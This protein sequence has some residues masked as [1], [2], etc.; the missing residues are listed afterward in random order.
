MTTVSYP[1]L[2]DADVIQVEFLTLRGVVRPLKLLVDSGF[3]GTSSVILSNDA[4]ELVRAEI[5]AA[6]AIGALRGAQN[7]A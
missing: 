5:Q 6:Q 7:R 4:A 3:T 2:D 1:S